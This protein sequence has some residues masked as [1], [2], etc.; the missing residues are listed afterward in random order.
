MSEHISIIGASFGG[1]STAIALKKLGISVNIYESTP[2]AWTVNAGIVLGANAMKVLSSLGL[3]EKVLPES[4]MRDTCTIFASNGKVLTQSKYKDP[5]V[6]TYTFIQ[7]STLIQILI[8]H[9]DSTI[10]FNK[11]L[12][13]FEQ[14]NDHVTLHFADGTVETTDYVIGTDG[15]H[16]TLRQN[17][18]PN[19]SLRYAG[20]TAW[21]GI[22]EN[23]PN[24][25]LNNYSETWGEKGK[26]GIV[27]LKNNCGYWYAFKNTKPNNPLF[28]GWDKNDLLHNFYTYHSPI[29]QILERTKQE[30]ITHHDIYDFEPLS[31]YKYNRVLL[32]GD[33][34]HAATPTM[35]QGACQT[36]EDALALAYCIAK[37]ETIDAAFTAFE[38]KR[39]KLASKFVNSSR[40]MGESSSEN[41]PLLTELRDELISRTPDVLYKS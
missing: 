35:G 33:A 16:S 20:Y 11:K 24:Y 31:Q 34:A 8:S 41:L 5:I 28:N 38:T 22:A 18:L 12:T 7:R 21:R 2:K 17:L 1:L 40:K 14:N 37:E 25:L 9:L 29:P 27:P 15:I 23:C 4:V 6:P 19:H 32:L 36:I 3:A 39:L 13:H 10:H 30:N 26:I